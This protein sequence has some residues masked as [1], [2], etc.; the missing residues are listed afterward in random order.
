[1]SSINVFKTT[2]LPFQGP[3]EAA[4]DSLKKFIDRHVLDN[5]EYKL[6]KYVTDGV[7]LRSSLIEALIDYLKSEELSDKSQLATSPMHIVNDFYML[8]V[9]TIA[10]SETMIRLAYALQDE[11]QKTTTPD[12]IKQKTVLTPQFFDSF[13]D[14]LKSLES[15][16]MRTSFQNLRNVQELK[17]KNVI[18][19]YW[20]NEGNLSKKEDTCYYDCEHYDLIQNYNTNSCEGDIHDCAFKIKVFTSEYFVLPS[21]DD[22]IY[23]GYSLSDA[24]Y[25]LPTPTG[26]SRTQMSSSVVLMYT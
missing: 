14:V 7:S 9:K 2:I 24:W 17:L 11:L 20:E 6:I 22:R 19:Y 3:K 8:T 5:N 1:M 26:T 10:K 25:G 4:I 18:Q 13:K 21:S 23:D 16:E 15:I 12:Y